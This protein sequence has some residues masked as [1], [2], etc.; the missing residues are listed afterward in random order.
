MTD[1]DRPMTFIE[2]QK[3]AALD[4]LRERGEE[5]RRIAEIVLGKN[6]GRD[7][8]TEVINLSGDYLVEVAT[9][10]SGVYWASL[11][12]GKRTG[13]FHVRQEDAILHLIAARYDPNPNTNTSAAF[14]AGRVLGVST[15]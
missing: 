4:E 11:V 14:Y 8:V 1:T 10:D 9:R 13:Q 3:E 2:R 5:R 15:D 6:R 7:Q 12:G